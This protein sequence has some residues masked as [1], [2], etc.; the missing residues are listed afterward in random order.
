MPVSKLLKLPYGSYLMVRLDYVIICQDELESK[1]MRIIEMYMED[2]RKILYKELLN[3][4]QSDI[5]PNAECEITRDVWP[6]ISHRLFKNDLYDQ[7]MADNTLKR[8][9]KSLLKKKF[10]K[11]RDNRTKRY[12]A[13]KYQINIEEVQK[14]L[15]SLGKL[16]KSEYQK[17]MVSKIDG[18]KNSSYQNLTPGDH[19]NLTPSGDSMVSK[20][21]PNSRKVT[22]SVEGVVEEDTEETSQSP[23]NDASATPSTPTLE[24]TEYLPDLTSTEQDSYSPVP[25]VSGYEK[26]E[27]DEDVRGSDRTGPTPGTEV[28]ASP[29]PVVPQ[30]RNTTHGGQTRQSTAATRQ[31]KGTTGNA[32]PEQTTLL[33][34]KKP[35]TLDARVDATFQMLDHVRQKA[36]GDPMASYVRSGKAKNQIKDLIKAC[37]DTPN[38]VNAPNITL[39]WM[40]M[41]NAPRWSDGQSWQDT[42]KLT[43]QAFCN[44]YGE[45]LDRGRQAAAP[46]PKKPTNPERGVSGLKRWVPPNGMSMQAASL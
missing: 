23:E 37:K 18:I 7:E 45:Y 24:N 31:G 34:E 38:E 19:Q 2:E 40:A 27:E 29:A 17:L 22:D 26:K 13:P 25:P 14:E 8:A 15:D 16:G 12:E 36:S 33:V 28:P 20:F 21:D 44:N 39:A 41:W 30:T 43:I 46:K 6:A 35:M 32:Q 1:I 4:P 9:I 3:N 42:G 10:I 5:D 11:M